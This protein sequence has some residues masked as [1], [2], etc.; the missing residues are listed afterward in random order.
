MYSLR[1]LLQQP[2]GARTAGT[3]ISRH[4]EGYDRFATTFKMEYGTS[5]VDVKAT[6]IARDLLVSIPTNFIAGASHASCMQHV[7]VTKF[8]LH[9]PVLFEYFERSAVSTLALT[10]L[11]TKV[12]ASCLDFNVVSILKAASTYLSNPA[13]TKDELPC[14]HFYS[15]AYGYAWALRT[16]LIAICFF[17][18]EMFVE[19]GFTEF[20]AFEILLTLTMTTTVL[21]RFSETT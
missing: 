16:L 7:R 6:D 10:H 13:R 18:N 17:N 3:E 8:V 15:G 21:K 4:V 14:R 19:D 5:F 9:N 2:G 11:N 1:T 20:L 12:L